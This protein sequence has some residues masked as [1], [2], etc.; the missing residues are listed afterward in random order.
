MQRQRDLV[1]G[2]NDL[3]S[4]YNDD[5]FLTAL[6]AL[7]LAFTYFTPREKHHLALTLREALGLQKTPEIAALLVDSATASRAL[8]FE[9]RLFANLGKYGVR[10][11]NH[12]SA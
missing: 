6:P 8:A 9:S 1:L 7:R 3:L 11:S 5:D 10:G 4:R 12:E 2:I